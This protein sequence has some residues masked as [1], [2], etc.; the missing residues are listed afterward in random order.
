MSAW[1]AQAPLPLLPAE[2]ISSSKH[3]EEAKDGGKDD[4]VSSHHQTTRP[5]LDLQ[6]NKCP[7][8]IKKNLFLT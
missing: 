2:V 4:P 1:V 3:E 8:E 6:D 7:L 5:P